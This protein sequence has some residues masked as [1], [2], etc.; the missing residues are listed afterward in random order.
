MKSQQIKQGGAE[1]FDAVGLKSEQ[2]Y[3][4]ITTKDRIRIKRD[5]EY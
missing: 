5:V 1:A 4:F 3:R 2:F